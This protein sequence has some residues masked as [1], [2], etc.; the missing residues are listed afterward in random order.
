[1]T[2]S[3]TRSLKSR[4]SWDAID[5][6]AVVRGASTAFSVLLLGGLLAP[7]VAAVF[8][9]LAMVWLPLTAVAAFVIAGVRAASS[10]WP[11]LGGAA[12]ALSGYLLILPLVLINPAGRHLGQIAATAATALLVG[13]IAAWYRAVRSRASAG[14]GAA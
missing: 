12:S 9:L 13:A 10:P 4:L 5:P 7:L 14:V 8:P 1:M 11:P 6:V 2:T 3:L